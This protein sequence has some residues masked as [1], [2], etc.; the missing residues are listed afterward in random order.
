MDYKYMLSRQRKGE[1]GFSRQRA[2][3]HRCS[4]AKCPPPSFHTISSVWILWSGYY[5]EHFV[6]EEHG[7]TEVKFFAHD[8]RSAKKGAEVNPGRLASK[9]IPQPLTENQIGTSVRSF[10]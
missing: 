2:S 10:S 6:E 9:F 4:H 3:R 7:H 5:S 1:E 8:Q